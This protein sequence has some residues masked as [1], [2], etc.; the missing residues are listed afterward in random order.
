MAIEFVDQGGIKV[1]VDLVAGG[2]VVQVNKLL[3]SAD[4]STTG[5]DRREGDPH[6][7]AGSGLGMLAIRRDLVTQSTGVIDGDEAELTVDAWQRLHV[8]PSG[9][10]RGRG[11]TLFWD[12]GNTTT[13][14][15]ATAHTTTGGT[16]FY[17]YSYSLLHTSAIT[18]RLYSAT[19]V[20]IELPLNPG[21]AERSSIDAPLFWT[22]VGENLRV[23]PAATPTAPGVAWQFRGY[24]Q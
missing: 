24:E 18:V 5:L 19:N 7:V 15:I 13:Q 11:S 6:P 23:E 21:V 1:A 3:E 10:T 17:V 12:K 22:N 9:F 4:A 14:T 20:L 2:G 8:N 16:R